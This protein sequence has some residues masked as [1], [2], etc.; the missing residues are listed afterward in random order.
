MNTYVLGFNEIDKTKLMTVGGRG[1]NLGEPIHIDGILVPE[2]FCVT[3]DAYKKV[4]QNALLNQLAP[5][6]AD[7]HEKIGDVSGK[8]RDV[9]EKIDI[10]K[11]IADIVAHHL[12]LLG[13]QHAYAIRSSATA[14]DLP[15]SSFAGQQDTYLNIKGRDSI[16]HHIKKC[17]ASLFTD[18]AFAYRIQNGFDHSKVYLSVVIQRMVFPQAAGILFTADPV[19]S[20]RKVLSIDAS[21]GLGE[22]LVSGLVNADLYKVR[23]GQIFEK[24][25][26]M[27]KLAIYALEQGGTEKRDIEPE[28][29]NAQTFL[30]NWTWTD[31]MTAYLK[32]R[33]PISGK[34]SRLTKKPGRSA[35]GKNA[36]ISMRSSM[37]WRTRRSPI[38]PR[39]R[40]I[41]RCNPGLA[42][43]AWPTYCW[44]WRRSRTP[45]TSW[46]LTTGSREIVRSSGTRKPCWSWRPTA[47]MNGRTG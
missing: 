10:P 1:A 36:H 23:D 29:Q 45:P 25:I 43:R 40:I 30:R 32:T 47:S 19:T 16:L 12:S 21:F 44:C 28:R 34:T 2:G 4:V 39:F 6:K 37:V 5:L 38:P 31:S 11:E 7:D 46:V 26:A 14:E 13:E 9:I 20:N 24:T 35:S 3:T 18:R 27:K 33:A 15:L 8:L 22:A 42:G 41:W 17:W